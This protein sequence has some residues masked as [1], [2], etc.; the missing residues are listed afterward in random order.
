ME[1]ETFFFFKYRWVRVEKE[2]KRFPQVR[3]NK[4]R[5]T[6]LLFSQPAF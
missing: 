1:T 5:V 2:L 6:I 4:L 3:V